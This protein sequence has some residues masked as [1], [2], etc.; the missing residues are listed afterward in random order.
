[1]KGCDNSYGDNDQGRCTQCG[2]ALPPLRRRWCSEHCER[3]WQ[4]NHVWPIARAAALARTGGTCELCRDPEDV[5]VHHDPPV[6]KHGYGHGCSHHQEKLH[7][8]CVDHHH[9]AHRALRAKPGTVI[10]L[11]LVG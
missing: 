5:E 8:L 7:P 2:E 6:G 1:M 3:I 9:E 11:S 10:Q 4:A